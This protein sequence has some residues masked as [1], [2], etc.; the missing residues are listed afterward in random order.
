MV[1]N[2]AQTLSHMPEDTICE[3]APLLGIDE[4]RAIQGFRYFKEFSL[5]S[6]YPSV[7]EAQDFLLVQRF[8]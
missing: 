4:L 8:A 5:H 6:K 1:H 3:L 2:D 7:E